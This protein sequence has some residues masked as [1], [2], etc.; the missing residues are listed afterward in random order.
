MLKEDWES[1]LLISDLF[2]FDK[3]FD[4]KI[5]IGT[6][7]AGRGPGAGPV[8]AAAVCFPVIDNEILKLFSKLNDSKKLSEKTRFELAPLIKGKSLWNVCFG[9]V[10][11]IENTN[12]LNTSLKCMKFACE[13]VLKQT[14]NPESFLILVDGNR[15][16]KN[17]EY[18]QK[19]IVKGDMKSA[20]IAAASVL[21]K[22]ERDIFMIN[23]AKKY[24]VYHWEQN[25]GYLTKEHLTSVDKYGLCPLHRKKFFVKHFEKA[26]QMSLFER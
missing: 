8:V 3:S 19:C 13:N 24:P 17:F 9:D 12:I 14:E 11:E 1:L 2:N 23:A 4:K 20:S 10:E 7:E 18:E 22:T 6:D 5:I 15:R 16:I 25:K 26:K 21:A